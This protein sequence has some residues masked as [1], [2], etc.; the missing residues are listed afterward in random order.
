MVLACKFLL[1]IY[2]IPITGSILIQSLEKRH[3][4]PTTISSDVIIMLGAGATDGT[5]D[6]SGEGHLSGH[7]VNRLL[8][9][10][11][12]Y[13]QTSLPIILSGR[14]VFPDS[15]NEAQIQNVN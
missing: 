4:V 9:V 14:S 13:K 10:A 3:H 11:R 12:L 15:G 7:A 1:Y 6:F 5:M 8:T 2:S